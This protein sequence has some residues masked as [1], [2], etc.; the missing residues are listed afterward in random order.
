MKLRQDQIDLVLSM[1]NSKVNNYAVPGLA[2]SLLSAPSENGCIRL[3]ESSRNHQE[4]FTPHSHR[5]DFVC[6]VMKGEVRNI[7]WHQ[8]YSDDHSNT[9]EFQ[10]SELTYQGEIG[11]YKKKP[12]KV[13]RFFTKET[14]HKA[15]DWYSMKSDEIHSIY[16][17]KDTV[18]LFFE[19][20]KLTDKTII[21]DPYVNGEHIPTFEV[22]PWM[23]NKGDSK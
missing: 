14:I 5:F 17:A 9:D 10:I 11:S 4:S 15:G 3:F 22:K 19:G 8:S 1:T 7:I 13:G 18:V 20:P 21:L 16:F 23:F 12:T 6:H 2:S